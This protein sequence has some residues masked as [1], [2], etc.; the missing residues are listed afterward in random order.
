METVIRN[1]EM[2]GIQHEMQREIWIVRVANMEFD[3]A[4][5]SE[6]KESDIT[7]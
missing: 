3:I 7:F 2:T 1:Q 4:E 6:N 5:E